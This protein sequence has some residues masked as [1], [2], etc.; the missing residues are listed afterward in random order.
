MRRKPRPPTIRPLMRAVLECP[1]DG[2]RNCFV[3]II[4]LLAASVCAGHPSW[5]P[6]SESP[7]T[8]PA[9]RRHGSDPECPPPMLRAA[10][11][12]GFWRRLENL[13]WPARGD[14]ARRSGT[15]RGARRSVSSGVLRRRAAAPRS[16]NTPA[17]LPT[18]GTFP[19][20]QPWPTSMVYWLRRFL[21]LEVLLQQMPDE[22][23][24]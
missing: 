19:R 4:A 5:L 18:L 23:G 6:G 14:A 1:L 17:Q 3:C 15:P 9:D 7:H 24:C 10:R 16:R 11:Q 20:D 12:K 22:A 2:L 8:S 21:A 13:E